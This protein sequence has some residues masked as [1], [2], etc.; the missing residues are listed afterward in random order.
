[1]TLSNGKMDNLL[2]GTLEPSTNPIITT[3]VQKQTVVLKYYSS[4][5][6]Q[7]VTLSLAWV[8]AAQDQPSVPAETSVTF[9]CSSYTANTPVTTPLTV[10]ATLDNGRW[11]GTFSHGT[12]R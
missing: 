2:V 1:V 6:T 4:N 7:K 3:T 5:Q 8:S 10:I 9:Q 12:R 11:M